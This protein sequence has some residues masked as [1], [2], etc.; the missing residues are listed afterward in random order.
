MP[1]FRL[2]DSF[3]SHPKVIAA[4]NE[5]IGL[6]VRCGTYAAEHSTDGIIS[7][8]IAVLYG[9]SDTGSRRNPGTGKPETLAE[10]LIR[11][12]LWRRVRGGWKMPDYLDYNPSKMA[13]DKERKAAAERQR[14]RR[15]V[16]VSRRDSRRDTAVSHSAPSRP[17]LSMADQSD[18]GTSGSARASPDLIDLIMTEILGTTGRHITAEWAQNIADHVLTGRTTASPLAYVRQAIRSEPDPKKRFLPLY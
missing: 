2:D 14:R 11:T 16:V 10:T 3:H 17:D 4:G 15:E 8:D 13:V 1:W 6:Y 18:L 7:E 5:A 12:T 9:A